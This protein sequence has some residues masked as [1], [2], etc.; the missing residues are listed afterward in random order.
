MNKIFVACAN[1]RLI[2]KH[3]TPFAHV[4][5]KPDYSKA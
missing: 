1:S 2:V 5:R 3:T 4:A